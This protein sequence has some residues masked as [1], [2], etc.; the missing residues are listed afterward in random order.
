MY[1]IVFAVA[2]VTIIGAVCAFMLVVASKV[3]AV[4]TDEREQVILDILPGLNCGVCGFAGCAGYASALLSGAKT[5]LCIPGGVAVSGK[6]SATLGVDY[7]DVN[8]MITV[9][10]CSGECTARHDKME[11]AGIKTCAAAKQLF[12]GQSACVYGCIGYG[13]CVSAC[14][15]GAVRII[16]GIALINASVCTGC[17]LCIKVCPNGVITA[18]I[19]TIRILVGC[20]NLEKGAKVRK[21]CERGCIACNR[22]GRECPA[23]AITIMDNLPVIDYGICEGCEHCTEICPVDCIQRISTLVDN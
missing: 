7:M 13:D 15:N 2:A 23:G 4:K 19:D 18:E 1:H 21:V 8:L 16:N 12:G 5:N 14:P 20:S 10:H 6:I 17:G 3:M 11:Y 9:V 22:C